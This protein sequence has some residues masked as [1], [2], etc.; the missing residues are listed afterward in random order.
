MKILIGYDGS[1]S[2]N[3]AIDDLRRAGLP[4]RG[5]AVA[6]SVAETWPHLP[7]VGGGLAPGLDDWMLPALEDARELSIIEV[8][9]G[10][11]SVAKAV[12]RVQSILPKWTVTGEAVADAPH[13]GLVKKADKWKPDLIVVGPHGR[14]V[15]GRLVLGSVSHSV[16]THAG[17]S[18]RIGRWSGKWER[19]PIRV[20]LGVDGSAG[21]AAAMSVVQARRWTPGS[22][23]RVISVVDSS[24]S[25][26][27]PVD[28]L[29]A[30]W[31]PVR[32]ESPIQWVTHAATHVARELKE[33]GLSAAHEV[34]EGNPRKVLIEEAERWNAD[35]IFVGAKGMS[36]LERFLM[37]SV[38]LAV[39]T[40]AHCS[41]EVVRQQ[42]DAGS[43]GKP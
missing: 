7:T 11:D 19:G 40:R 14:S 26:A 23:V 34:C 5:E 3:A 25:T 28:G 22:E 41:V 13:W 12:K 2:A 6:L 38:S 33:A 18:V 15:V 37:G 20:V 4:E 39:A 35:C 29:A 17:C 9:R 16:L 1:E 43:T 30:G 36:R 10:S 32:Y 27:L 24:I 8:K 31:L 42:N 21:S